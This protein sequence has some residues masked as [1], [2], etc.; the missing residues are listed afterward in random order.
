MALGVGETHSLRPPKRAGGSRGVTQR[1]TGCA[2]QPQD[3]ISLDASPV[4]ERP[5]ESCVH[6]LEDAMLGCDVDGEGAGLMGWVRLCL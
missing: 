5:E 3:L 6:P 4:R 2:C 1:C